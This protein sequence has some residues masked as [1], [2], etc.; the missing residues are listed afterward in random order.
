MGHLLFRLRPGHSAFAG[1]FFFFFRHLRLNGIEN[2]WRLRGLILFS[3]FLFLYIFFSDTLH[4]HCGLCCWTIHSVE[5]SR[6]GESC[7][8]PPCFAYMRVCVVGSG[9]GKCHHSVRTCF[10]AFL[11]MI[12]FF[13]CLLIMKWAED[14]IICMLAIAAVQL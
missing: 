13:L 12:F 6:Q 3:L 7:P 14:T 8:P 4:V 9:L 2:S 10:A 5:Y 11:L 1:L